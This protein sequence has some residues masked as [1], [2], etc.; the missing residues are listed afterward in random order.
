MPA[1]SSTPRSMPKLKTPAYPY[2]LSDANDR[3]AVARIDKDSDPLL[4]S[5]KH[6]VDKQ[7]RLITYERIER[8]RAVREMREQND[9]LREQLRQVGG[10]EEED[11]EGVGR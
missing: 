10:G 3:S 4:D 2:N 5:I 8:E 7:N 9:S 1:K 6:L 11:G